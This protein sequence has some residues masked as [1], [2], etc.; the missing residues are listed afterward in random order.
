MDTVHT[1]DPRLDHP[2]LPLNSYYFKPY[3]SAPL[4]FSSEWEENTANSPANKPPHVLLL[5]EYPQ[6]PDSPSKSKMATSTQVVLET[7]SKKPTRAAPIH[8]VTPA[9]SGASPATR[10]VGKADLAA[11]TPP[12]VRRSEKNVHPMD[13]LWAMINDITGKDKLAK[14]G[15]Y[16]L[17]LL[18]HHA[19]LSQEYLSDDK[20]NIRLIS[21]TYSSTDKVLD[22]VV[23]F[24][25][26]PRQFA[27]VLGILVC[28]VFQLRL[29]AVVPALALYRQLLR[30]GKTPFRVR[31]IY[32]KLRKHMYLDAGKI[33]RID[34]LFFSNS[35]L[36]ECISLYYSINDE[37]LLLY[38][39]KFLTNATWR[40]IA[41]RHESYAWYCDSWFALYNAY[42]NLQRLSHQ[43]MDMR[44]QIQVKKRARTLSRQLLGGNALVSTTPL[45]EDDSHDVQM[46]KDI[47]FKMTNARLDIYKTLSDIIFNSYTVFNARLHFATIQIWMGISASFLSSVKLYREK[48]RAMIST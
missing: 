42:N 40:R 44:I 33:W 2:P 17:R 41:G 35:T 28:L 15:Q 1:T 47:R 18:L 21:K 19:K 45:A 11:P 5:L 27:R 23:N 48:K 34:D 38:K 24:T 16:L 29:A 14:F 37:S 39:L 12:P 30:F 3:A 9:H 8:L 25:K 7:P 22:L 43:E 20:L 32:N 36:G 46:L 6:T 26:N 13:V 31:S 4:H 10:F